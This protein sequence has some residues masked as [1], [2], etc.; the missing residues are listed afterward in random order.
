MQELAEVSAART[1][2]MRRIR[3]RDTKP[4]MRVRRA[5]HAAGLRE[6]LHSKKLPGTPDLVLTGRKATVFVHGCFWHRHPDPN[7][8]LARLPKSRLEF[9]EPKLTSNRT[10]DVRIKADIEERG[11]FVFEVWECQTG[12][13]ELQ[14]LAEQLKA[15][16][17][18]GC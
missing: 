2:Q 1:E 16:P 11:W 10:R 14:R 13:A 7:C 3:A 5:L 12:Q 8:K 18:C 4:E 6:G 15:L 17:K 9:W